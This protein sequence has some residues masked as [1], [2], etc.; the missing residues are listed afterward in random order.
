MTTRLMNETIIIRNAPIIP[1]LVFRRFRGETDYPHMA[2]LIDACKV[3]DGIERS[4]TI[5]D[6]AITYRHLE[7][8][9]PQ[10]D[11][12]FAEV[13]GQAIAYG[14]IWWDD[15]A[16]GNRLYHPFGFLH[17]DWRH[18]GIGSVLWMEAERRV[19]EIASA[20]P[21]ET[22]K[23]FQVEPFTTEKDL[24][25]LLESRG[26]QPCRYET[27]MLRDLGEPF[28]EAPMPAGLEVRPVMSE[29]IRPIFIASNEAFRDH[30]GVRDESEEEFKA[31]QENPDFHP[32]LWKVAWEGDQVA[33]VIH[34]FIDK[35]ENDEYKR[36]R[37]YTEG[38][39][40][41]R[42]WRK[43]GL[44]RS[45][46][47]QSMQ[48]FKEKGMTETALSVDSENLSGALRLY[49]DVGYRNVKQ[50]IIYRKPVE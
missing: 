28:P 18:K 50:Q 46:L 26:Y 24:I 35:D 5:E 27:H 3:A 40:T 37:G 21:K 4:T 31:Q 7:N 29:H 44:A 41:R 36:K 47:V 8:S 12:L 15:L 22:P 2:A 30:W 1:G 20:H 38:I 23:F 14:R 16:D 11:M 42:P 34:N 49:E 6:I 48:M 43:L 25:A 33:S 45:L 9:D 17:P 13:D 19:G 32:E 10:T 39:C